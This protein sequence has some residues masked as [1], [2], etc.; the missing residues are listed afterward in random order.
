MRLLTTNKRLGVHRHRKNAS[1][2]DLRGLLAAPSVYA[3]MKWW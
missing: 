1:R 3:A 2:S